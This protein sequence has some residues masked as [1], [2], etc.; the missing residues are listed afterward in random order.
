MQEENSQ[1]QYFSEINTRIK[2]LEERQRTLKDRVLIIGSNLLEIKKD[3]SETIIEIKKEIEL[4]K[5][6]SERAK[7]FIETLSDEFS[8]LARKEDLNRLIKQAKMFQP[9]EMIQEKN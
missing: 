7:S 9:L 8:K 4:L 1:G 3:L 5:R 6:N 2:D